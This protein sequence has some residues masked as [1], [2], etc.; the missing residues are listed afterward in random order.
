VRNVLKNKYELNLYYEGYELLL[1]YTTIMK[2]YAAAM[3]IY[4][5]Q[6][7]LYFAQNTH[8]RILHPRSEFHVLHLFA[9]YRQ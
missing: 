7:R 9:N 1:P 6:T 8:M 5:S 4:L 3:W 2:S